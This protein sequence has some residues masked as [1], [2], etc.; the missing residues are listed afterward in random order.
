MKELPHSRWQTIRLLLAALVLVLFA[1]AF[2]GFGGLIAPLAHLQF[3]PA[4]AGCFAAFT[5]GALITVL[6]IALFTFLFGRIYCSVLCSFGI[7]Q[8]LIAFPLRKRKIRLCRQ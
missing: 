1:L 8:D 7:L 3:A 2:S 6:G 5:A 4:L